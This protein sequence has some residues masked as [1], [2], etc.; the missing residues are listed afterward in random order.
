VRTITVLTEADV[1]QIVARELESL[2]IQL[3]AQL[4]QL[5]DPLT[6]RS[7]HEIEW[8]VR[9]LKLFAAAELRTLEEVAAATE[10]TLR[11]YRNVGNRTIWEIRGKLAEAGLQLLP[12]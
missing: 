10:K 3:R 9:A 1:R 7:V 5:P 4:R 12:F 6:G 11:T 8:S 2:G